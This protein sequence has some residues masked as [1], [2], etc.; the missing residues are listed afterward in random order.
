MS[1]RSHTYIVIIIV[2]ILIC[3]SIPLH[4]LLNQIRVNT[5]YSPIKQTNIDTVD[6]LLYSFLG[7][8]RISLADLTW[9][10][11]GI[12]FH[13]GYIVGKEYTKSLFKPYIPIHEHTTEGA[14]EMLPWIWLTVKINPQHIRAY[15]TGAFWLAFYLNKVDVGLHFIDEGIRN[16][17]DDYKGYFTKGRI[18]FTKK[19]D[20]PLAKQYFKK[21]SELEI[22]DDEDFQ[23]TFRYL[24]F[25]YELLGDFEQAVAIWQKLHTK[26]PNEP[27]IE[28]ELNKIK[29]LLDEKTSLSPAEKEALIQQLDFISDPMAH[30][31]H[32]ELDHTHNHTDESEHSHHEHKD[33]NHTHNE[34]N[35]HHH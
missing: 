16:N 8:L 23:E 29:K 13:K 9:Y 33:E 6:E 4:S 20:L 28:W 15:A 2:I 7:E 10:Y 30:D 22:K 32:H 1:K 17:P 18:I 26:F 14:K 19:R 31:H 21:A 11:S 34:N 5:G 12:V 25:T 35:S 3:L 24:A 27:K